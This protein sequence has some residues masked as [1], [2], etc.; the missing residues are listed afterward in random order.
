MGNATNINHPNQLLVR[1][2]ETYHQ[3]I[4]HAP[5]STKAIYQKKLKSYA[6]RGTRF[7]MKC[8]TEWIYNRKFRGSTKGWEKGWFR[9]DQGW[10]RM[11][12]A[13]SVLSFNFYF[14]YFL[15]TCAPCLGRVGRGNPLTN[16]VPYQPEV[17]A[18]CC[19]L[20]GL[21]TRQW[22]D[23]K[24]ENHGRCFPWALSQRNT[25]GLFVLPVFMEL[26]V[27]VLLLSVRLHFWLGLCGKCLLLIL[28]FSLSFAGRLWKTG[29]NTSL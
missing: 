14:T 21:E 29:T 28:E 11:A 9:V 3:A 18:A 10:A 19:R 24:S 27:K 12:S 23:Q 7:S 26:P 20:E 16:L 25:I 17:W 13:E 1:S 22:R 2:H 4:A 5:K 15:F 8:Q 6:L